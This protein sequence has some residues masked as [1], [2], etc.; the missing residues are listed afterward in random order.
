MSQTKDNKKCS[1]RKKKEKKEKDN[2]KHNNQRVAVKT[3]R[4]TAP[5]GLEGGGDKQNKKKVVPKFKC[6]KCNPIQSLA[7]YQQFVEHMQTKHSKK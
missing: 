2:K 3:S 7:N 1:V 6:K 5:K 4:Y